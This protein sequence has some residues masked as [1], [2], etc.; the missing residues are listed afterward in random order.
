MW[1]FIDFLAAEVQ[2]EEVMEYL[3]FYA[4]TGIFVLFVIFLGFVFS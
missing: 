3:L 4:G 2:K 1:S